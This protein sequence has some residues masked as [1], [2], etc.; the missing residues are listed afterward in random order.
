MSPDV[1]IGLLETEID[2]VWTASVDEFNTRANVIQTLENDLHAVEAD[3]LA[4]LNALLTSLVD[5][6][7]DI[8]H[9]PPDAVERR[10]HSHVKEMNLH[11]IRNNASIDELL[12]ALNINEVKRKAQVR[13]EWELKK[14]QWR[15]LRY[16]RMISDYQATLSSP[17]FKR[18]EGRV[19]LSQLLIKEQTHLRN[20]LF[21]KLDLL[22]EMCPPNADPEKVKNLSQ[23][24]QDFYSEADQDCDNVLCKLEAHEEELHKRAK[25]LCEELRGKL[26][27]IGEHSEA[28]MDKDIL[29]HC[30]QPEDRRH[31]RA[32]QML[33]LARQRHEEQEAELIRNI[34]A[35]CQYY[36]G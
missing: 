33:A 25:A 3:R 12:A 11:A 8:A 27:L 24:I 13:A 35:I 36:L 32:L 16:G 14:L 26:L 34:D 20:T 28:E 10:L 30:L 17:Q 6:L 22:L 1:I 9:E 29:E 4:R 7:V 2:G 18:P 31:E 21:Q 23:E 15:S 5:H 19:Q